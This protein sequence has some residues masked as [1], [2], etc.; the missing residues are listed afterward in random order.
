MCVCVCLCVPPCLCVHRY[1]SVNDIDDYYRK[2]DPKPLI[3]CHFAKGL[4]EKAY[5]EVQDYPTLYKTLM[6]A[7]NGEQ[8][9]THTHRNTYIET[10]LL[11]RTA[12]RNTC[13]MQ[14]ALDKAHV[15]PR[16]HACPS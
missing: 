13:C 16:A 2:K 5:D 7:L 1:F 15:Y 8:G 3:F 11:L 4:T 12:L 9:L 10:R 14:G 6:E